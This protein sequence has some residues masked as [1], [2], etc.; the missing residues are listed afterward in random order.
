MLQLPLHYFW[1]AA[2]LNSNMPF[3]T[4]CH[5][6]KFIERS[7][8]GYCM[9]LLY[10]LVH[11]SPRSSRAWLMQVLLEVLLVAQRKVI[12]PDSCRS[13]EVFVCPI[14]VSCAPCYQICW[15]R[16]IA[17]ASC[18][19]CWMVC[20]CG[21][22]LRKPPLLPCGVSSTICCLETIQQGCDC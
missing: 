17:S 4:E 3:S 15:A 5:D 12:C 18:R 22:G 6:H 19:W 9:V 21:C 20:C 11:R 7:H 13:D 16:H 1:R 14:R 2:G 8:G 10:R